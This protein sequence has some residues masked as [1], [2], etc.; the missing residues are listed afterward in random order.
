MGCLF[1]FFAIGAP[2]LAVLLLWMARPETFAATLSNSWLLGPLIG[3]FFLP[4]TTLLYVLLWA[5]GVGLVGLDWLWVGLAFLLD[6][7]ALFG[8]GWAQRRSGSGYKG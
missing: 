5:P 2:R 1:A 7:G 4:L 3:I 8:S 6:I